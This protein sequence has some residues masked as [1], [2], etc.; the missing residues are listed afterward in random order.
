MLSLRG[1]LGFYNERLG[2][3]AAIGAR[4][5]NFNLRSIKAIEI[6]AT[7]AALCFGA[8]PFYCCGS[9]G[10]GIVGKCHS[11][12]RGRYSLRTMDIVSTIQF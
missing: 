7:A 8:R 12:D 2:V 11:S 6:V 10:I 5:L 4:T 1:L 9:H 3:N